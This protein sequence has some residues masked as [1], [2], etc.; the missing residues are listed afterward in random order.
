M[1]QKKEAPYT[2]RVASHSGRGG[3]WNGQRG[4]IGIGRLTPHRRR[5]SR[6]SSTKDRTTQGR[7]VSGLGGEKWVAMESV[8]ASQYEPP[9]F[10]VVVESSRE[11]ALRAAEVYRIT[12][13]VVADPEAAIRSA[14]GV[15][16]TPYGF[17]V[18]GTGGCA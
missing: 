17:S 7:P 14:L 3:A 10:V 9:S 13:P 15:T 8:R 18:D 5:A 2:P 1:D 4:G 16:R 11:E 6:P 12:D